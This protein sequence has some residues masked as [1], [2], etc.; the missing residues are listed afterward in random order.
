MKN[1]LVAFF[2]ITIPSTQAQKNLEGL[3]E[4]FMS[5]N[6]HIIAG[7]Y[8]RV[9]ELLPREM[10]KL[11]PRTVLAKA[12]EQALVSDDFEFQFKQPPGINKTEKIFEDEGNSYQVFY[13]QQVLGIKFKEIPDPADTEDAIAFTNALRLELLQASYKDSSITFNKETNFYEISAVKKAVAIK[14]ADTT[15]LH[16]AVIEE[17]KKALMSKVFTKKVLKKIY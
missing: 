6:E 10:F 2:L 1:L 4:E 11:V 15:H 9:V 17:S 8:D 14:Y 3:Q 12:M 7:N 13:Y 5:Y 16:F